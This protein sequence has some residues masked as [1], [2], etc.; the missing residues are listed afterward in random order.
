MTV[1]TLRRV[2]LLNAETSPVSCL[3]LFA[4]AWIPAPVIGCGNIAADWAETLIAALSQLMTKGTRLSVTVPER[5]SR[6]ILSRS[7]WLK[8]GRIDTSPNSTQM[9]KLKTVRDWAVGVLERPSV[10][11]HAGA[12]GYRKRAVS[13]RFGAKPKPARIGFIDTCEESFC[14]G[15]HG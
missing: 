8:M 13:A 9:V 12:V 7:H 4:R 15:S 11:F 6:E 2:A 10:R 3:R 5:R 1:F 14:D